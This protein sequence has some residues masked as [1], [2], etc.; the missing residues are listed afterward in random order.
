ME[1]L[2]ARNSASEPAPELTSPPPGGGGSQRRWFR[3]LIWLVLGALVGAAVAHYALERPALDAAQART[4]AQEVELAALRG[5]LEQ[6]NLKA[7]VL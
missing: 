2:Q 1:S 5:T 6:A 7:I 4:Q 3:I